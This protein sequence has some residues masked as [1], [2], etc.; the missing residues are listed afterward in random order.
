[1]GFWIREFNGIKEFKGVVG[2]VPSR[3]VEFG[4]TVVGLG[5]KNAT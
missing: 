3:F 1:M 4:G 2:F 5:M